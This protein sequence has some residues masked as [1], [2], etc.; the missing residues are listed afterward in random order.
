MLA[1]AMVTFREGLEA[2]L[3]IAISVV[4]F[5]SMQA[6]NL[7]RAVW[8]GA[9]LALGSCIGLGF[10]FAKIGGLAPIWEAYLATLAAILVVS[11]TW[12]MLHHGR[13]MGQ[14]VS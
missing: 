9:G 1:I 5:S 14:N 10:V 7:V 13:K 4:Y 6:M 8:L 12:H 3:I 11:C 2:L